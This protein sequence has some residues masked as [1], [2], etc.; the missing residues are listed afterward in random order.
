MIGYIVYIL[1]HYKIKNQHCYFQKRNLKKVLRIL[2]IFAIPY[3]LNNDIYNDNNNNNYHY[4]LEKGKQQYL[5]DTYL[6][7]IKNKMNQYVGKREFNFILNGI[8][9]CIYE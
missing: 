9:K 6:M 4:Y 3:R 7:Q 8:K 1:L 5:F 2:K